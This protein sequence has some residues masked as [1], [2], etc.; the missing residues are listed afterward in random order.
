[1]TQ[2]SHSAIALLAA[3]LTRVQLEGR[4]SLPAVDDAD[5]VKLRFSI[6]NTIKRVRR[7][8][9]S[10]TGEALA[11]LQEILRNYDSVQVGIATNGTPAAVVIT[12]QDRTETAS[13]LMTALTQTAE[14][15]AAL[16]TLAE[17]KAEEV[18]AAERSQRRYLESLG[19]TPEASAASQPLSAATGRI[20]RYKIKGD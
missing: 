9:K 16:Q 18:D 3:T 20:D 6:Y 1:M 2:E 17:R 10:A 13:R 19:I 7:Q 4:V 5:A 11:E 8:V 14:G 12:R 15:Q